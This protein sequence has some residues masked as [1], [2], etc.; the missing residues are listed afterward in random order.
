M[1]RRNNNQL[2]SNLSQLQN[3]IKRDADSYKDEFKQQL[4]HFEAVLEV[5]ETDPSAC[6]RDYEDLVT[7]LAHV[8]HCYSQE[9]SSFPSRLVSLLQKYG[10]ILH[11]ATRMVSWLLS[12]TLDD[13]DS[14]DRRHARH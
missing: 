11:P 1:S 14:V 8:S 5:T 9:M 12:V 10:P 7:F 13:S 4:R 2:P 6:S 3:C